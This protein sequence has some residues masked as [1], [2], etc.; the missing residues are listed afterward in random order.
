MANI[1][2]AIKRIKTTAA[3]TARNRQYKS[4]VH[5]AERRLQQAIENGG[6]EEI[7]QRLRIFTKTIDKAAQKGIIHPNKAARS[8]A[9]L[10][11]AAQRAVSQA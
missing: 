6:P 8:K 11:R 1:K 4:R 5:T 10:T 9:R 2:S 7:A 3:R